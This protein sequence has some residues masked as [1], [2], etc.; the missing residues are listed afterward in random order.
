MSRRRPRKGGSK[1]QVLVRHS[2]PSEG[3]I[4]SSPVSSLP[5]AWHYKKYSKSPA[6]AS[7]ESTARAH[8]L[9]LW[10]TPTPVAPWTYRKRSG[11]PGSALKILVNGIFPLSAKVPLGWTPFGQTASSQ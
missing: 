2:C 6:L 7:L 11:V 5:P 9:G 10:G 8:N 3:W 4:R 1:L